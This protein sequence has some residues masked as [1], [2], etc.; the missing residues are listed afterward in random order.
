M[1]ITKQHLLPHLVA[2]IIL[3]FSFAAHGQDGLS[4]SHTTY[5]GKPAFSKDGET[6]QIT[7]MANGDSGSWYVRL[8]AKEGAGYCFSTTV[9][10]KNIQGKG[11][12][13]YVSFRSE[14]ENIKEVFG[15]FIASAEDEKTMAFQTLA[16]AGTVSMIVRLNLS[17]SSGEAVF[18]KIGVREID[19]NALA[20]PEVSG[21]VF[22]DSNHNGIPDPDEKGIAN[23][24]VSDGLAIAVTD[25][26]G[27]FRIARPAED[28]AAFHVFAS[29][30]SGYAPVAYTSWFKEINPA[31]TEKKP[32]SF[33]FVKSAENQDSF[34]FIHFSDTHMQASN[35]GA[36]DK[37][38][39]IYKYC[40]GSRTWDV[41]FG[42]YLS[43]M[44][45]Q[46]PEPAFMMD[47]GDIG[48]AEISR[49]PEK[50][51]VLYRQ[52]LDA[53][54]KLV[55]FVP[56]NH[57]K[58][59][60]EKIMPPYYAFNWGKFHFVCLKYTYPGL[61]ETHLKKQF[62]WLKN[63]LALQ[64]RDISIIVFVH[65]PFWDAK[66]AEQEEFYSILSGH[67]VKAVFFGHQ[68][69]I[70]QR[71]S[72]GIP[73]ILS[74][75]V[76][77]GSRCNRVGYPSGY[78]Q[79]FIE[80]GE[81]A[82]TVYKS[83]ESDNPIAFLCPKDGMV[84]EGLKYPYFSGN[85]GKEWDGKIRT[86]FL[87]MDHENVTA[88]EY[89]LDGKEWQKMQ[90]EDAEFYQRWAGA[91]NCAAN[92]SPGKHTLEARASTR[93]G[94]TFSNSIQFYTRREFLPGKNMF[95]N[96]SFEISGAGSRM[97]EGWT[98]ENYTDSIL[99]DDRTAKTGTHS[100]KFVNFPHGK[101]VEMLSNPME[102]DSSKLYN[103]SMWVKAEK[104]TGGYLLFTGFGDSTFLSFPTGTYD[105]KEINAQVLIKPGVT[106]VGFLFSNWGEAGTGTLWI[107]DVEL[108]PCQ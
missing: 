45:S 6:L 103:L 93:T 77:L 98:R 40:Q 64:P 16:P 84:T 74:S 88:M 7:G 31:E 106:H 17:E 8:P 43:K 61:N 15:P 34:S 25:S 104:V 19:A 39:A 49:E 96:P 42:K 105:W 23:V 62:S 13:W 44:A 100:M 2:G 3:L 75:A 82:R 48:L 68:H 85:D 35:P 52:K 30:P 4:W 87:D 33:A 92:L 91:Q 83:L 27:K 94:K 70:I 46:K 20:K 29:I 63:D 60:T 99:W 41:F 89:R 81:I 12:R 26:S 58:R 66:P 38:H 28:M 53:A 54:S 1:K 79:V 107:D 65:Y 9:K 101:I 57:D 102:V 69:A 21:I 24:Q 14:K 11:V 108:K 18:K 72:H 36:T 59:E 50:E 86:A 5:K 47:T 78:R 67:Q 71:Q 76:Y 97:P 32:V 73:H 95:P 55:F 37:F 22:E 80:G 51:A 56:G 90:H 10:L